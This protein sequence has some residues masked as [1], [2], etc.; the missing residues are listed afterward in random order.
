M[1]V[2]IYH[3]PACGTS[4]NALAMIRNAG[5]DPNIVEYLKTP[6]SRNELLNLVARMG[7]TLRDVLRRKGTPFGELGLGDPAVSDSAR[8][9]A[10]ARHPI[11]I[12]RPIVVTP[13]GV[14]LCR[15]S[16]LVLD[17]LDAPQRSNFV[18][19]DGEPVVVATVIGAAGLDELAA[20][21]NAAGLPT[22]DLALP[23][24]RFYRFATTL[25]ET[26]AVGGLEGTDGDRLLRSLAV[27]PASRGQGFGKAVAAS[28]ERLAGADGGKR[29]HVLTTT[30]APF[31]ERLGYAPADRASA[32]AD[33]G[34]SAEFRELCPAT[35]CYLTKDV[36][37]S[38]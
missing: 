24:R 10:V 18:K 12:N 38:W 8:L 17:L 21:L 6:P 5:I 23:G 13:R 34:N 28:L 37:K 26:I 16:E 7:V 29:L 2:T 31:F 27:A 15:P 4:R 33:I 30:A 11:L 32:P 9:D 25:G 19:E 3:N 36:R 22:A 1:A 14:K 35:A 20:L